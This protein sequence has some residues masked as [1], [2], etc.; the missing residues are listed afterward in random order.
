[1]G[2]DLEGT[3]KDVLEGTVLRAFTE[4]TE[5]VP[6]QMKPTVFQIT[7]HLTVGWSVNSKAETMW[8]TAVMVLDVLR[9]T[10]LPSDSRTV[11]RVEIL[12]QNFLYTYQENIQ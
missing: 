3:G 7:Q 10:M 4:K 12:T 8:K 2:R 6:F 9:K 11:I 1:M 5:F